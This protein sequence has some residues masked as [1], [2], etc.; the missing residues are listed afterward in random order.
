M[1]YLVKWMG[2][3]KI[4]TMRIDA[5]LLKKAHELGLNV[6]KVCE[7]AL[8]EAIERMERPRTETNGGTRSDSNMARGV[9]FEPTRPLLT[10]GL[11]GLPPT[12]LGQP[13]TSFF[14]SELDS[15]RFW[16]MEKLALH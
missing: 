6:T 2:K 15:L 3:K 1:T 16:S 13:R 9:G 7:N 14:K 11:A 4:T 10:T 5:D 8:K 12:R